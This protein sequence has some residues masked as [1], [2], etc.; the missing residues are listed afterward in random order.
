[1]AGRGGAFAVVRGLGGAGPAGRERYG[2]ARRVRGYEGDPV[3]RDD[4]RARGPER[5][6]HGAGGPGPVAVPFL[7][8][9]R[10]APPPALFGHPRCGRPVQI[11]W[12]FPT[13]LLTRRSVTG[14]P[15]SP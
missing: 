2:L 4:R 11:R 15:P 8:Y 14:G 6:A 9:G 5:G 12:R 10:G 13:P 1:M 7:P 3:A